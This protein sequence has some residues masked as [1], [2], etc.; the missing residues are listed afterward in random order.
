MR[1]FATTTCILLLLPGFTLTA[2][3]STLRSAAE[4]SRHLNCHSPDCSSFVLTAK[5]TVVRHD[6]NSER[7][8]ERI[9]A[10]GLEDD[11]G[12]TLVACPRTNNVRAVEG[13]LVRAEGTICLLSERKE[14]NALLTKLTKI[15]YEPPTPPRF[16]TFQ[17]IQDGSLDYRIARLTGT[18]RDAARSDTNYSWIILKLVI[19]GDQLLDVSVQSVGKDRNRIL[20]LIGS[21]IQVDGIVLPHDRSLRTKMGHIFWCWTDR[22]VRQISH[23]DECPRTIPDINSLNGLHPS[24]ILRKGRHKATGKVLATWRENNLL[25]RT[26]QDE[27]CRIELSESALP[28]YGDTIEAIGFPES[29]L[30]HLNLVRATWK[31]TDP[32]SI[33]QD[34]TAASAPDGIMVG[35][36]LPGIIDM[37][38]HGRT[39]C[40]SGIIRSIPG[41]DSSDGIMHIQ[42]GQS[43][44]SVD[45]SSN[46]RITDGLSVGCRISVTGT[47]VVDTPNWTPNALCQKLDRFLLVVRTPADIE[48]LSRPSWWTTTRLLA[49]GGIL[50]ALLVAVLIWNRSLIVL[51]ERRGRELLR[52][53]IGHVRANLKIDERT[54]LA[55]DLHDSLSQ[56]LTGISFQLDLLGRLT[57]KTDPTVTKH[58]D[59][60]AR[61]LQSCRDE[62]RGCIW[63]LRSQALDAPTL[64]EAIRMTL[65][66]HLDVAKLSLRFPVPRRKLDD[67]TAHTLLRIIR[68]LVSNAL[69]HG[70]AKSI[71]IA[72][73]LDGKQ[74]LASVQ[75]DG[76]GFD[77]ATRPNSGAGH[78]GLD[79][80]RE[81]L[82]HF[83]GKLTIDSSPG[84]GTKVT[85]T[86]CLPNDES[87]DGERY[88]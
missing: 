51:A 3:D 41:G 31:K 82:R 46:P 61:T 58:L 54:R 63:D 28:A 33:P 27:I 5:V 45:I 38:Y 70:A 44:I 13:D 7:I 42:D 62:L 4:V 84:K 19:D 72:G 15:G 56:N 24:T 37:R 87:D 67:N 32:I 25:I 6:S 80:I 66:P 40:A 65:H 74:L 8:L 75:D 77:P 20:S 30:Y 34:P 83:D 11:T 2:Q 9:S 49:A 14:R 88:G 52:E 21:T 47:C 53:Q 69:R 59:I 55:V 86:I 71:R 79:G 48:V 73:A 12:A 39:I 78:F 81:R 50:L 76:N 22:N 29:D 35:G 26:A 23:P 18:V 57:G 16:A 36:W 10:L 43:T 1:T 85:F 64:E 60:A 68:E 17:T